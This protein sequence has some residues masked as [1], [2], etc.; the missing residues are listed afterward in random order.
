[1]T[2][3]YLPYKCRLQYRGHIAVQ[4]ATTAP[5]CTS[6]WTHMS[7]SP[8]A[9][10]FFGLHNIPCTAHWTGVQTECASGETQTKTPSLLVIRAFTV[11]TEPLGHRREATACISPPLMLLIL[12]KNVP[13]LTALLCDFSREI[14]GINWYFTEVLYLGITWLFYELALC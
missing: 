4:P 14:E 8:T 11:V 5:P 2:S 13:N 1:M 12:A 9:G 7:R 6:Q 3:S 10:L